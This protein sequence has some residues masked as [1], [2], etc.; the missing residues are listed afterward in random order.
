MHLFSPSHSGHRSCPSLSFL[1]ETRAL[2]F[3]CIDSTLINGWVTEE[4]AS[5]EWWWCSSIQNGKHHVEEPKPR[6]YL[7]PQQVWCLHWCPSPVPV[8][9][10]PPCCADCLLPRLVQ[11]LFQGL[12]CWR[13]VHFLQAA[14]RQPVEPQQRIQLSLYF[15]NRCQD[16]ITLL[17]PR[18]SRSTVGGCTCQRWKIWWLS[19]LL[20]V[21][22]W[23][24][25]RCLFT[26][27]RMVVRLHWYSVHR[28]WFHL[29]IHHMI[30]RTGKLGL[31]T[32]VCF[33]YKMWYRLS[34]LLC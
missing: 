4:K 5:S 24:L 7:T 19:G 18:R 2:Q 3:Y 6:L 32:H 30:F 15:L 1:W 21:M 28:Y 26:H 25:Y 11:L 17:S 9:P 14:L 31:I 8:G 16:Q 33:V 20:R 27:W 12:S 23:H 13:C 10:A 22:W 29:K 34:I